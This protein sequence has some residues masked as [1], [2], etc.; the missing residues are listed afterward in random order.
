MIVWMKVIVKTYKFRTV[1]YNE[2]RCPVRRRSYGVV[3]V[4]LRQACFFADSFHHIT[5]VIYAKG[6]ILVQSAVS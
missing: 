6:S 1:V 4:S 3:S 2:A 5:K